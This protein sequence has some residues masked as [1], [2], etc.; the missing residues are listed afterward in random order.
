M[1]NV[2]KVTLIANMC[3]A[4]FFY[5]KLYYI[6]DN[7]NC[8]KNHLNCQCVMRHFYCKMYLIEDNEK[9]TEVTFIAN[10]LCGILLQYRTL[11][12]IHSSP[13]APHSQLS[14]V[15]GEGCSPLLWP[16]IQM[17]INTV[18]AQ[19]ITCAQSIAHSHIGDNI[20]KKKT[21]FLKNYFYRR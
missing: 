10:V 9:C 7:E 4:A 15:R 8:T 21:K 5:S 13:P 2:P 1:K 20:C 12:T 3:Y 19:S 11:L 18:G 16:V 6:E 14:C 17:L